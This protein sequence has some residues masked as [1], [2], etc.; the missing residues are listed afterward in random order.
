MHPDNSKF[1]KLSQVMM[2]WFSFFDRLTRKSF[3]FNY[4]NSIIVYNTSFKSIFPKCFDI[5]K[6]KTHIASLLVSILKKCC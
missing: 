2:I 3:L 4:V 5:K 6:I 1:Q